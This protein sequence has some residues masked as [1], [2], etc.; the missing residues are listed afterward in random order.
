M[1]LPKEWLDKAKTNLSQIKYDDQTLTDGV[2][3]DETVEK[4]GVTMAT[5]MLKAV[6]AL[7]NSKME[8]AY[9]K[10]NAEPDL[11]GSYLVEVHYYQNLLTELKSIKPNV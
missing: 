5:E 2:Y 1:E 9:I 7:V 4:F 10:S 6:E 3:I 8:Q 11:K